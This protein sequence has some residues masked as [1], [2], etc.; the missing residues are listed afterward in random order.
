M[1][2]R[3]SFLTG[4]E[5]PIRASLASVG[6]VGSVAAFA[7]LIACTGAAPSSPPVRDPA[8]ASPP[9]AAA[10][11][12]EGGD[13]RDVAVGDAGGGR[14][15]L[16]SALVGKPGLVSLWAPWCAPC[17][18]EQPALER[19]ARAADTCGGIVVA[20][21]VGETPDTVAT[22][23]R[24]RGLSFRQL[25]DERFELADALGRRRIPAII[26]LDRTGHVVFS[27]EALDA[28]A[29]AA[30][31]GAIRPSPDGPPCALP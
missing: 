7:A 22:F 3:A 24:S 27:G 31:G 26:V 5:A 28:R 19:L 17:V 23:A 1:R 4:A 20:V 9:A 11:G 16:R 29:T 10:R 15:T 2:L 13:F 14:T 21:A 30:L 8:S 25:T 18:R 12:A 6:R